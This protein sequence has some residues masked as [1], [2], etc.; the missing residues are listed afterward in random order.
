MMVTVAPGFYGIFQYDDSTV[1]QL[2]QA[3]QQFHTLW[4]DLLATAATHYSS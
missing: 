4:N 1:N 2:P 3:L